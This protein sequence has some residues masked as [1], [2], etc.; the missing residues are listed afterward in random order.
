VKC[1][2]APPS[3]ALTTSAGIRRG[4][5]CSVTRSAIAATSSASGF[6]YA[7]GWGKPCLQYRVTECEILLI[8]KEAV[9]SAAYH[10]NGTQT[11]LERMALAIEN[12]P[13]R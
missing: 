5:K 2:F 13:T 1:S 9:K 12:G 8:C 6:S 4:F 10:P 7:T 11:V 3:S